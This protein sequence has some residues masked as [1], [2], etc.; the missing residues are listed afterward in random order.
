VEDAR[1]SL[2]VIFELHH[3]SEI[4]YTDEKLLRPASKVPFIPDQFQSSLQGLLR[5]RCECTLLCLG[6]IIAVEGEMQRRNYFDFQVKY[7]SLLT[8]FNQ[9]FIVCSAC[10]ICSRC[11]GSVTLL[12]WKARYSRKTT[13]RPSKVAFIID[14][15]QPN[16]HYL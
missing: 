14:R 1:G 16:L 7:P 10:A 9:T 8:D 15:F 2:D 6:Y 4:R 12:E 13:R 5:M 11:Y 3:C